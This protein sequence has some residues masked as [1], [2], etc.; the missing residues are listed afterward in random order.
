M[1]FKPGPSLLYGGEGLFAIQPIP[2]S[3]VIFAETPILAV[4]RPEGL[5][6]QDHV[7]FNP[8]NDVHAPFHDRLRQAFDALSLNDQAKF[9][10]LSAFPR[11][12]PPEERQHHCDAFC[13]AKTRLLDIA[14]SSGATSVM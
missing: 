2:K 10:S 13:L 6:P 11:Q 5:Q 4:Q 7:L 9:L 3:T 14:R 1:L 12:P 8:H